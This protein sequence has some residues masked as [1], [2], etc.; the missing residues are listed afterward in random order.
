[1]QYT[2]PK[3]IMEDVPMEGDAA[4]QVCASS[5]A[6][7]FEASVPAYACLLSLRGAG[8]PNQPSWDVQS[9]HC[10]IAVDAAATIE[11]GVITHVQ[12]AALNQ[13][14]RI[15]DRE[16][17]YRKRRLARMISPA[18]NDAFAMGDQ[19]PDARVSTYADRMREAQIARERDNTL[20]VLRLPAAACQPLHT[21][22]SRSSPVPSGSFHPA[23]ICLG[24]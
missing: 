16:D 11:H 5:A 21:R 13:G 7:P 20:Q 15:A 9:Q 19:T 1:M 3:K 17:D 22:P 12:D 18:R 4:E 10:A 24:V 6:V 23:R 2:A 8:Q 14:R